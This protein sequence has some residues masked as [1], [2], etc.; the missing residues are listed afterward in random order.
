LAAVPGVSECTLT[1]ATVADLPASAPAAPW[2][3]LRLTSIVWLARGGRAAGRAAGAANPARGRALGV[4]GAMV[5]YADTP[6]GPYYEVLG[7]VGL[8]AG[9]TV[10]NSVPF[11]A[12][13]SPASLVG[14]R[15][16]WSL[17]KTLAE[18]TGEPADGAMSARGDGW[19][20]RVRARP[21]GPSVPIPMSGRIVQQ[22]PDGQLRAA[23]L[24]GKGRG[25]SAIVTVEVE[26][27]GD[28]PN[29]LRSGRH[30]GV[31]VSEAWFTMQPA[32]S[33]GRAG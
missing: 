21:Y 32:V 20:V 26:S 11:M 22:W 33:A 23:A 19:S 18:F 10:H 7:A 27:D 14:G 16:N 5:S 28:L 9:R 25:R 3:D 31:V 15:T 1:A 8:R 6:V 29:W 17:P 12:V 4:V 13:D 30:L 2:H 24:A